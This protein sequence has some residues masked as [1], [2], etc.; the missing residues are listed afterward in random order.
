MDRGDHDVAGPLHPTHVP[1]TRASPVSGRRAREVHAGPIRGCGPAR[2]DAA[3]R[4][5]R[6]RRRAPARLRRAGRQ[7]AAAPRLRSVRPPPLAARQRPG[8]R[9]SREATVAEVEHVIVGQRA[10]VRSGHGQTGQVGGSHPVVHAP[11][12]RELIAAG[13]ARLQVHH[14]DVGAG[15]IEHR[16]G[17]SPG[18]REV[19]R[20]RYRTVCRLREPR[21]MPA[22][23]RRAAPAASGRRGSAGSGRRR[24]RASRRRRSTASR[25]AMVEVPSRRRVPAGMDVCLQHQNGHGSWRRRAHA[26]DWHGCLVTQPSPTEEGLTFGAVADTQSAHEH[27]QC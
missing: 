18:P 6:T 12:R 26:R 22:R 24:G 21:H 27:S 3:G 25:T 19:D 13:D 1:V 9:A 2:R 20:P 4:A 17:I 5:F 16:Q 8:C 15:P 14:A 23:R 10:N 7:R 11:S